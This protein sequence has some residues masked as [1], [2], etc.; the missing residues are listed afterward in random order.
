MTTLAEMTPEQRAECVGMWC[1]VKH[2]TGTVLGI[3]DRI[4]VNE[5]DGSVDVIE[6]YT[7]QRGDRKLP[8]RYFD[9]VT[10]RFDL[11]RAWTPD[12]QPAPMEL[13]TSRH[14]MGE[15]I[16][17]YLTQL[18]DRGSAVYVLANGETQPY[19]YTI[20]RICKGGVVPES[21]HILLDNA[22]AHL[23]QLME[24]Q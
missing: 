8:G 13:E 19:Q 3:I 20:F 23:K 1:D 15:S 5:G 16:T 22:L 9:E 6:P 4:L 11:P 24:Q 21:R 10:P 17:R 7:G 18:Q 12:G 2:Y 14:R